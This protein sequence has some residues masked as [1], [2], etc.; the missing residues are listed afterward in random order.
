MEMKKRLCGKILDEMKK[1][2][3]GKDDQLRLLL[4]ALLSKGHIL[5]EDVP[6]VGKTTAA[7]AMARA[8]GLEAKRV[9][10][11][12]D[13][14]ATDISGFTAPDGK[15]GEFVYRPGVCMTN[16]LIA[17]EIN[18]TSPKTQSALL[19]VMEE[20]QVTVDGVTHKL[21]EPF[22]VVATQNP[23]GYIG[24]YPLPEAQLDRFLMKMSMG[25]PTADQE[26]LI[27]GDR[28]GINPMDSVEAVA[29]PEEILV[30]QK[31]VEEIHVDDAIKQYIVELVCATRENNMI[32]LA[33]S[34]RASLALMRAA[35]ASALLEGRSYVIPR[36]VAEMYEAI[37]SHRLMLSPEAKIERL[38]ASDILENLRDTVKAPILK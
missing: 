31:A 7:V 18:R 34:P 32:A 27:I 36:D 24:T 3:I 12:P 21:P 14:M 29:S 16:I 19:E 28:H 2:I 11:T 5:V 17:D 8:T 9:Q 30:L 10:F 15:T 35:C 20:R 22:M 38:T 33:A 6:G 26:A 1:V 4:I 23:L 25:Y 37:V 13:V